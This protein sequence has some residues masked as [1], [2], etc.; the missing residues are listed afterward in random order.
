MIFESKLKAGEVLGDRYRIVRPVG[1][2]G[3]SRVF[4]A[5][6][7]RLHGKRWA[8][9]ESISPV[10]TYGDIEA[11]AKLLISLSH[12]LL[13]RVGD[14]FPPD[15]DGYC[16]LVMDYIEGVTLG[17]Y[18]SAGPEPLAVKSIL[19]YAR[20]LLEVLQYLH[21]QHP[22]IVHRD[23]KPG[24]IMLTGGDELLLIDFGIAR[25]FKSGGGEDTEKLGTV[26]FAAPEQYGGGQSHPVSDLYGLGALLLY[27]ATGGQFS[28]W[29]PGMEN[30]LRSR[31]P[32]AMIPVIRRLLRHHPEDRYQ[33]AAEVLLA[34]EPIEAEIEHIQ[35][36]SGFSS[37]TAF[38]RRNQASIII[39][40]LGVA[41]GLGTTHTSLAVSSCLGRIGSTAWVDASPDS[42]VY[43]RICNLLE[44][45]NTAGSGS[46]EA[47]LIWRGVHYWRKVPGGDVSERLNHEYTYV[48]LDLGT[49]GNAGALEEF[50]AS[51]LPLLVASG[52]DWRLEETLKWLDRHGL[53]PQP[54]W[55]ICLPLA[56]RAA[57][58][59]LGSVLGSNQ[60]HTLPYQPDP[61]QQKGKLIDK[62]NEL[63]QELLPGRKYARRG[64]IFQKK[65]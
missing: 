59:L 5:E 6:D 9:K 54:G 23:M 58:G 37:Q 34:L 41:P 24:N 53:E 51:D 28:R 13:P 18:I 19:R 32:D 2:G 64:G 50:A 29:Q 20:Q 48:V 10:G 60:V 45:P 35:G 26:G 46:A 63:L 25:K 56:S 17:E 15:Q 39:A 11:E 62:L 21:G 30:E 22:P 3:M 55:R 65:S 44:T 38:V 14:F 57:A 61:F 43:N 40:L 27:M 1:T 47:P 36:S 31:L 12:P 16:Y 52:A 49:A 4:L 7:L 8:V 42:A 33:N